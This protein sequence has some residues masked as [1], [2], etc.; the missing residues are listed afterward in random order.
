MDKI[1]LIGL[2]HEANGV[3]HDAAPALTVEILRAADP[4]EI[5]RLEA[6]HDLALLIVDTTS[7]EAEKCRQALSLSPVTPLLFIT[8]PEQTPEIP[9]S[10]TQGPFRDAIPQAL[11]PSLLPGRIQTLLHIHHLH[12]ELIASRTLLQKE[13]DK[14]R[15]WQ[16]SFEQHS[17]YLNMLSKRDGLTG[18]FNR[19][20]LRHVLEQEL[21]TAKTQNTDL[22]LLLLDIDYFNE[23]NRI[24]G[25]H[26]GDSILNEFAARLTQNSGQG[27]FCFRFGGSNFIVLLPKTDSTKAVQQ[28]E[29][30]RRACSGK[31]FTSGHHSRSV[32]VSIGVITLHE[33]NPENP[34]DFLSMAEKA[35]Y[36]AKSQ[37]RNRVVVY[38]RNHA[39]QNGTIDSIA[40][41]QERLNQI[42]EKT[43]DSSIASLQI[44][45]QNVIGSSED[46]HIHQA[47]RYIHLLCG[48]LGFPDTL[49]DTFSNA[50]ILY[51]SYRLLL[52][53]ELLN[54]KETYTREERKILQDLPYKLGEL[55]QHFDY[56]AN[57]RTML[58]CQGEHYDGSGYP[59]GLAGEEIPLASRIFSLANGLAAMNADRPHRKR[60]S[61]RAI[62]DE[63]RQG[64]GTQWDPDL[65]LLA[66]D[67]IHEQQ[68]IPFD[69]KLLTETR[70]LISKK[71]SETSNRPLPSLPPKSSH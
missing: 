40:L 23:T 13:E 66:L 43:K 9:D 18:L 11:V 22:S 28:A 7:P 71:N 37:G 6:E 60:L 25:Q 1:L 56:F 32:T 54:K 61:P 17:H 31:P 36:Q 20:H 27:A 34:D 57:E 65:V 3:V 46:E 50:L 16:Q 44:L 51:N 55:T 21:Q 30:L 29:E 12:R 48:R 15:Q 63:L 33:H 38:N 39:V 26:F 68:I 59:E 2:N 8:G 64:A 41:L 4:Q 47:S 49:L 62:L 69:E 67:I 35:T 5:Q 24:A 53:R 19:R 52:Y 58:L 70:L 14:N 45:T 42:L 10:N